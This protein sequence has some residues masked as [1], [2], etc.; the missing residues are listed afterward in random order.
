MRAIILDEMDGT[1][2]VLPIPE[3][4]ESDPDGFVISHPAYDESTS[5]YWIT[6]NDEI[7][8]VNVVEDGK[9][10]DGYPCYDYQHLC[11]L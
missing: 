1:L 6:K 3:G 9:D 4:W 5:Y 2:L 7:D 10:D 11:S 8:V